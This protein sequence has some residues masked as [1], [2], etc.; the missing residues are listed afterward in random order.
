[1]INAGGDTD[2]GGLIDY[3]GLSLIALAK[4]ELDLCIEVEY[5]GEGCAKEYEELILCVAM[6]YA[7]KEEGL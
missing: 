6:L 4:G 3:V 7:V 5:V 1:M 2:D